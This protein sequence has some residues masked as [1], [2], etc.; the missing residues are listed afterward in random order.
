MKQVSS[1]RW[2][3]SFENGTIFQRW[4]IQNSKKDENVQEKADENADELYN[5]DAQS[6]SGDG[7]PDSDYKP[8]QTVEGGFTIARDDV[9]KYWDRR[10]N[11]KINF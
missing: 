2:T 10:P 6:D 8:L 9:M 1:N 11:V 7:E 3:F 5:D 4:K